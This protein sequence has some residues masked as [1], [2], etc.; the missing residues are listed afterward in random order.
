MDDFT[1]QIIAD[2]GDWSETEVLG[3]GM[4]QALVKIRM[5]TS[6]LLVSIVGTSG[7]RRLPKDNLADRLLGISPQQLD[8][9]QS[10]LLKAG[11][12]QVEIDDTMSLDWSNKTLGDMLTFWATRRLEPRYDVP[13]DAIICDG[14]PLPCKSI[15]T[16]D[17]EIF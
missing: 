12:E 8:A 6:E 14:P 15:N 7:F 1:P 5:Q 4:G 9:I 17:S 3:V 2:G 16:V 11:Y 10:L 13:T